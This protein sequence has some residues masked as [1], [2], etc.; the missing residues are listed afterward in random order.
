MHKNRLFAAL[1]LAVLAVASPWASAEPPAT[2]TPTV[3]DAVLQEETN[4]GTSLPAELEK[5][6]TPAPTPA[7]GRIWGPCNILLNCPDGSVIG[8]S[9]QN[10]CDWKYASPSSPGFVQCDQQPFVYC[11]LN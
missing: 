10:H 9:G 5:Q 1:T 3:E 2:G 11:P 7:Y 4:T 8:C 6:L